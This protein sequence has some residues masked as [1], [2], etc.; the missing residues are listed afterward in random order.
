MT[1]KRISLGFVITFALI[2]QSMPAS[3]AALTIMRFAPSVTTTLDQ[4]QITLTPPL[5][6]SPAKFRVEVADPT[7]ARVDGLVVTLLAVGSTVITY[8]QDAVPGYTADSRTSRIYVRPGVPNLGVWAE[9]S[10]PMSANTFTLTPPTS[11]SNGN[12]AYESSDKNVI[13]I[14]GNVATII[15]GGEAT[16]TASQFRTASWLGATAS[17]KITITAPFPV[18]SSIPDISLSVNGISSFELKNPTSTSAAPWVFTS[19]NPSV[20]SVTGNKFVAIAPGSVTVTARQARMGIYRSYTTTFRV[21]VLAINPTITN[22]RFTSATITLT[23]EVIDFSLFAPTSESPGTW[24][25]TSSD[26][27]IV[28]VNSV[29]AAN[30]I[31]ATALKVGEINLTARQHA[32]G[33]FAAS[34]PIAV[35]ITVRGTP[36][37]SKLADIE[38][39]AGDPAITLKAPES[40]SD[41][42]WSFTS[43]NPDVA[44]IAGNILTFTGAGSAVIT[45]TQEATALWNATSTSFDVRVGGITP[46]VGVANPLSVDVGEVLDSA[47]LPTSNSLGKWVFTS[48]NPA[49][50]KIVNGAVVGVAVGNTKITL[51]Q[52][53]AG[54]YGRSNITSFELTVTPAP[55]KP[56][57]VVKPPVVIKPA[58]PRATAGASLSGRTITVI[59]KN[60]RAADVKVTINR[61]AA[62]L[63]LNTVK[64]GTRVVVVQH[65]G[66]TIYTKKFQ[67]K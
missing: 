42:L 18:V 64:A 49:I 9:R 45:A 8:I 47:G 67:V 11:Q 23:S 60:A 28:R 35:K 61:V 14:L 63:G 53:P 39:V 58:A 3:V 43:S 41:G 62:K 55:P 2:A 22:S 1:I 16:V 20:V 33:T 32:I 29:S 17:T 65:L 37:A 56:V 66:K 4:G 5:S 40:A 51:Y 10:V 27:T 19:S 52:E 13:T 38:R 30:L 54:K 21:D 48:E 59:A 34:E 46:T 31:S 6:N 44:S 7:I 50:A 26:P 12:W 15:D 36:V 57:V 25:V 24:E